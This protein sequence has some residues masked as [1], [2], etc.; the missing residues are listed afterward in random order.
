MAARKTDRLQRFRV[1]S[2]LIATDDNNDLLST[3]KRNANKHSLKSL[4]STTPTSPKLPGT[5][6]FRESRR[7][8]IWA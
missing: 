7:N 6:K 5:E 8:G 1:V 4:N 3:V 2:R